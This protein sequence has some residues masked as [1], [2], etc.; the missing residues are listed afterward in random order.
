MNRHETLI[1]S[2]IIPVY[3]KED[4]IESCIE[5]IG[6]QNVDKSQI[7]AIF[8]DDGSKDNSLLMLEAFAA[9]F[10]WVKVISQENGGVCSARNRGIAAA[11]GKYLFYLDPDD[12]WS[13]NVIADVAAFFDAHYDDVDLVTYPIIPVEDGKEKRL[14]YRYDIL[15][16]SGVYDLDEGDN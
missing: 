11:R 16:E 1:A 7:E 4:Y 12:S 3:N 10:P 8:V 14:H 13:E 2:G 15:G 9:E 5:T 6:L